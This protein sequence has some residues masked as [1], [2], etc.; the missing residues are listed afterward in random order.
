MHSLNRHLFNIYYV[1]GTVLDIKGRTVK[2]ADKNPCPPKICIL[3]IRKSTSKIH[4]IP[5]D[6]SLREK[7]I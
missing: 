3:E 6:K 4:N 7:L 2:K 5:V 1:S